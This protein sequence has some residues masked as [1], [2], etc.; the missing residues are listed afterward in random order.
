MPTME[1]YAKQPREQ[2]ADLL[3]NLDDPRAAADQLLDQR[4]AAHDYRPARPMNPA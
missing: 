1:E 2:R 3:P 4:H